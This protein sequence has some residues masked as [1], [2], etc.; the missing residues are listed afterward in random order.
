MSAPRVTAD[1]SKVGLAA[2]GHPWP[3]LCARPWAW[4]FIQSDLRDPTDGQNH[5]SL[6]GWELSLHI[7]GA[8]VSPSP[9]GQAPRGGNELTKV[10]GLAPFVPRQR[11]TPSEAHTVGAPETLS[12]R[13]SGPLPAPELTPGVRVPPLRPRPGPCGIPKVGGR[14]KEV[15]RA[16]PLRRV[17]GA[18]PPSSAGPPPGVGVAG[19]APRKVCFCLGAVGEGA[20]GAV[21]GEG[22]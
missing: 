18:K 11:P 15:P 7:Y 3:T 16:R 14:R 17:G 1:T 19:H 22:I 21:G 10:P 9:H 12:E 6:S 13:R 20:A 8:S 5:R 4:G 2:W